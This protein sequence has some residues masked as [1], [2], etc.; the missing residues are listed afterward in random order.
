MSESLNEAYAQAA[1]PTQKLSGEIR[2]ALL[3]WLTEEND[4]GFDRE[5]LHYSTDLWPGKCERAT[6]YSLHGTPRDPETL[7]SQLRFRGG[8]IL[9]ATLANALGHAG[10]EVQTKVPVRPLRPSAW[11]WAPGHAD[12]LVVTWKKLIE[13]RAPRANVFY[14]AAGNPRALVKEQYRWQTSTFFHELRRR[15]LVERA[16]ILFLDREGANEPAEVDIDDTLLVPLDKIV[17]EEERKARLLTLDQPPSRVR[18]T[19]RFDALKA[20]RA[21]VANPEPERVVRATA[22]LN[23]QCRYCPFRWTCQP[24]PDEAPVSISN[25]LRARVVAE[26]ERRWA[27]GEKRVSLAI[28]SDEDATAQEAVGSP[29]DGA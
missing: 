10:L 13:V 17:A 14:R 25:K 19:F 23:W 6:W 15:G 1:A 18:G 5:R 3:D 7:G 2:G 27:A 22:E 28:G 12:L 29:G 26:A 4:T 8:R 16:S 11:A 9:E 20:G 24:G 21:T